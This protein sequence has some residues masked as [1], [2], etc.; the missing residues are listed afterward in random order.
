M[1][2]NVKQGGIWRPIK[3]PYIKQGGLWVP[4][5]EGL[6]KKGGVWEKWFTS[7][8]AAAP[9]QI[10]DLQVVSY[11]Y[12]ATLTI[13]LKWTPPAGVVDYV[14]DVFRVSGSNTP[15]LCWKGAPI[16]G[17]GT[18]G[19]RD[20][21]PF[22]T[23]TITPSPDGEYTYTTPYV[24][25]T[26]VYLFRLTPRNAIGS[27]A[28]PSN[29]PWI[30]SWNNNTAVPLPTPLQA[31]DI[32]M[33]PSGVSAS[34][35]VS[36]TV[37]TTNATAW[38]R[39]QAAFVGPRTG[40][41]SAGS[42]YNTDRGSQAQT[43][44]TVDFTIS[45]WFPY[46]VMTIAFAYQGSSSIYNSGNISMI[47]GYGIVRNPVFVNAS[48]KNGSIPFTVVAAANTYEGGAFP[49]IGFTKA[50]YGSN[51]SNIGS[52]TPAN[53]QDYG[54]QFDHRGIVRSGGAACAWWLGNPSALIDQNGIRCMGYGDANELARYVLAGKSAFVLDSGSGTSTWQW[55]GT[56]SSDAAHLEPIWGLRNGQTYNF[57]IN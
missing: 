4:V 2:G 25:S 40:N 52:V 55:V 53:Y 45:S 48:N 54:V 10:T 32:V 36:C 19:E 37:P 39:T 41:L 49:D 12:A 1:P 42:G 7:A 11:A 24:G 35:T 5:K 14:L 3:K 47:P 21:V 20:Y 43:K 51:P 27:A 46:G 22:Q 17:D 28:W 18:G 56:T 9:A 34:C 30:M 57:Y 8:P 50:G 29:A 15:I 33:T 31:S 13:G 23:L 38:A 16:N 6:A 26:Y 44:P